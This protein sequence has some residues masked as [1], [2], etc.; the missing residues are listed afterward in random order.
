MF[1]F[2]AAG[3]NMWI[4][5][6]EQATEKVERANEYLG[7]V[8]ERQDFLDLTIV[9]CTAMESSFGTIYLTGFEDAN[10]NLLV[11]FASKQIGEV[12]EKLSLKATIKKQEEY[13]G[14]KQTIITRGAK[15]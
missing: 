1:A 7:T 11:W 8:G 10:G 5:S 12:G 13:N 3:V 6:Q 2:I 15:L 14:R 4:K 9:R